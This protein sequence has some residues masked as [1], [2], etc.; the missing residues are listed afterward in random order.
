MS[1]FKEYL[2]EGS[3][4]ESDQLQKLFNI[5]KIALMPEKELTKPEMINGKLCFDGKIPDRGQGNTLVFS[6]EIDMVKKH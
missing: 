3:L 2:N 6:F 5:I 4:S 1:R